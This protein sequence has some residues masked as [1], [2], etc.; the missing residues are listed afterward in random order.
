MKH[1]PVAGRK[2]TPRFKNINIIK[3]QQP[4]DT[5]TLYLYIVLN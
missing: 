5:S 3:C 2:T 1:R 4:R